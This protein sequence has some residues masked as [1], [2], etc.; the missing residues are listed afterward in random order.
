MRIEGVSGEGPAAGRGGRQVLEAP[1]GAF[2]LIDESYNGNP[3]SVRAALENLGRIPV[4]G[5]GRRVA[6]LGDL[7]ELGPAGPD[8]HKALASV[9]EANRIDKVFACGPLMRGL[10]DGLPSALR[11][12]YASQSSGLEPLVLDAIRPGDVVTVKGSLSSKMGPI[13]K[14]I[15]ARFPAAPAED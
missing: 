3:A 5:R 9:V 13:V 11:G 1:G 7:L 4:E 12:A 15:Q 8:L 14:A 6:V 10:Y 2:T